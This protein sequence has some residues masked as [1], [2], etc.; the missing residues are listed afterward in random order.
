MKIVSYI[1]DGVQKW[2]AVT[3]DNEVVD[4]TCN[5]PTLK[6]ALAGNAIHLSPNK[7]Y[8]KVSLE[9]IELLPVVPNPDKIFCIGIAYHDHRKETG[10][11]NS[12]H[13][14]VFTRFADSQVAHN[15]PI[16]VPLESEQLDF[17][18][19]LAIIIGKGGRRIAVEDAWSHVAGYAPYCDATIR[20]WQHHTSQWTPGKNFPAT[21]AF[22]PWMVTRDEIEDGRPLTLVTRL[23]GKEVQRATTDQLIFSIPEIIAYCSSFTELKPGDV[24]ATGTPG[25]VGGKR[26]PPLWMKSGDLLE[27]DIEA[28]GV[29]ANCIEEEMH[30]K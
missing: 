7:D 5:A 25:G 8:V 28:V 22:G 14:T 15:K 1:H 10:R 17:E 26:T 29:L 18:G 30:D 19:E 21:G 6:A 2:G 16:V 4:L 27:I 24:I 11:K 20:D 23:N 3:E 13:P 12:E 9:E